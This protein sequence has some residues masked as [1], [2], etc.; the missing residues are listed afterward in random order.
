MKDNLLMELMRLP[1]SPNSNC[2]GGGYREL[3][4]SLSGHCSRFRGAILGLG[5][6]MLRKWWH[7]ICCRSQVRQVNVCDSHEQRGQKTLK[8][9]HLTDGTD[10]KVWIHY[11]INNDRV[12]CAVLV[13][14]QVP[15]PR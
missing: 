1:Q 7:L 3:T 14:K 9:Y 8:K 15:E 13:V 4:L 11:Q 6:A 5:L 12:L 2:S 10:G